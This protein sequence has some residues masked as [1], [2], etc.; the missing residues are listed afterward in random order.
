VNGLKVFGRAVLASTLLI[1]CANHGAADGDRDEQPLHSYLEAAQLTG[2]YL[3]VVSTSI[4]P[5]VPVLYVAQIEAEQ[6]GDTLSL[7]LRERPLSKLDR[8]TQVGSWSD[9]TEASVDRDGFLSSETLA[10]TIPADANALTG[11]DSDVEIVLSGQLD[12][13]EAGEPLGFLC[14]DV[15]GRVMNPFPIDDLSGSAF[16]A[17]RID[18]L[19]D[20]E[21]Y[22]E[23]EINCAHE[24]A[25]PL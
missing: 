14:G 13:Q 23:V 2:S 22:P 3:L 25:R 6:V 12:A 24:P 5:R 10:I 19:A 21:G 18:D 7:R 4:A 16:T 8:K 1:A 17:T 20:V 9:W 15:V 11:L